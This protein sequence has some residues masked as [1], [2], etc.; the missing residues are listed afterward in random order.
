MRK[1]ICPFCSNEI[2]IE[3]AE[4]WVNFEEPSTHFVLMCMKCGA[5]FKVDV[6]EE[7]D[8]LTHE[9]IY[10]NFRKLIE[11]EVRV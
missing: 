8:Y 6:T 1:P 4:L 9:E 7:A 2:G 3:G 5:R 10:E 11:G